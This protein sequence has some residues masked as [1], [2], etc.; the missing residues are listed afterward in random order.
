[1]IERINVNSFSIDERI[2]I[3][4]DKECHSFDDNQSFMFGKLRC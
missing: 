3:F 2:F 1:M 4:F